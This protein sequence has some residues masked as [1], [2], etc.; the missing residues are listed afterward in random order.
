MDRRP[1]QDHRCRQ[2]RAS[3]VRFDPLVSGAKPKCVLAPDLPNKQTGEKVEIGPDLWEF[4]VSGEERTRPRRADEY[5]GRMV[6]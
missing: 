2:A 6:L 3:S 5:L 1:R 4:V